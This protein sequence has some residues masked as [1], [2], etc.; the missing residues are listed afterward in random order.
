MLP[1]LVQWHDVTFRITTGTHLSVLLVADAAE[2]TMPALSWREPQR[3]KRLWF[4]THLK[5]SRLQGANSRVNDVGSIAAQRTPLH[6][7][8][9]TCIALVPEQ[10]TCLQM[11][12]YWFSTGGVS[13]P[14][15]IKTVTIATM[16]RWLTLRIL[17]TAILMSNNC[18][19]SRLKPYAYSCP[20]PFSSEENGIDFDELTTIVGWPIRLLIDLND[21]EILLLPDLLSSSLSNTSQ[22]K[23]AICR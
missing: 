5:C 3:D 22:V 8:H 7:L 14:R 18:A 19:W 13:V 6:R 20:L 15:V 12:V 23:A 11:S 17:A 1:V 16:Q 9:L 21:I 10:I 4:E 2:V